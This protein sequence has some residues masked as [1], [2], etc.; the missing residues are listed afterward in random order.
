M[1]SHKDHLNQSNLNI[2]LN[3]MY[4]KQISND[5]VPTHMISHI[6]THSIHSFY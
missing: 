1:K 4:S 6:E 5:Y 3:F 2:S